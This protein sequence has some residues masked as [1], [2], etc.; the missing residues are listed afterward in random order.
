VEYFS[1]CLHEFS[2]ILKRAN[3][4]AQIAFAHRRLAKAE[5]NLGL[6]GWQ[7]ADFDES[8]QRQVDSLQNIEREQANLTNRSAELAHELAGLSEK[9][10]KFREE[11]NQKR[12][13][14]NSERDKVRQPLIELERKL[15]S[16]RDHTPDID[17]K[18]AQY[19]REL[20]D[21]EELSTKLLV[22]QPQPIHVRDEILRLRDRTLAIQNERNDLRTQ[23]AR[24]LSE[25]HQLEQQI[26]AIEKRSAEFDRT[27]RDVKAKFDEEDAKL[28]EEERLCA[29][30][31]EGVESEA[32]ELERAKGNPYRAIGRV[33][34]DNMIA[35]MNQ[36]GAL[37][38]VVELRE[39][40][41]SSESEIANLYRQTRSS[42][43][44]RLWI[45]YGLWGMILAAA[46]L[47]IAAFQ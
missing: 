21:I 16:A 14:L 9:R 36:P 8:T 7:Q 23:H 28:A 34:A 25:V 12:G 22:V 44:T 3:C 2:R 46:I 33:L 15:E 19:E 20:R 45:S 40:I 1:P 5:E 30:K 37:E 11:Y 39:R 38:K 17:R 6:L 32:N 35:P 18:T 47:V 29:E 4:R 10:V 13:T 27:L 42:D 41:A 24:S 31:K 43:Q 26:A